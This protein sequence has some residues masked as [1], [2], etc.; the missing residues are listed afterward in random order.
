MGNTTKE[1]YDRMAGR[2]KNPASKLPG[3]FTSDNLLAVAN[4]LAR[5]YSME[6]DQLIRRSHYR[7]AA[8]EDL[9][10][11]AKENHGMVRN[12]ATREEVYLTITGQPGA[13]IKEGLGIRCQELVYQVAGTYLVGESGEV[14]VLARCVHTG[15]GYHVPAG[16]EW[17]FLE[18]SSGLE[19]ARNDEASNGGYDTET[20]EEFR[21]RIEEEERVIVGYGNIAWYRKTAL[22]VTG[23]GAAKVFDLSRGLG[24]VDVVIVEKGNE[25]ASELL[26]KRVAEH[27][28][29]ERVPGADVLVESGRKIE[30]RVCAGVYLH[31]GVSVVSVQTEFK[32]G[33]RDYLE[34]MGFRDSSVRTRISHAKIGNIL[35]SCQGV[36]DVED[37]QINDSD[38]SLVLDPRS[39]PAAL[40]P[41]L[42]PKEESYR[43]GETYAER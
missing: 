14:Q 37:L 33:L 32:T 20:D 15:S 21:E 11:T 23:V 42:I 34:N 16:A 43:E 13:E 24:T 10:R 41:V 26:V 18:D 38:Q 39:F 35:L 31:P 40:D 19:E 3:S 25:E 30:V 27:I 9:D 12:P 17:K 28:E 7:T 29:S 2:L 5:I 36:M 6:Y 4:E 8:G 22:E 1:V